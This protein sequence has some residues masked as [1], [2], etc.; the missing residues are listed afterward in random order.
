MIGHAQDVFGT[1]EE[2]VGL[3]NEHQLT[4]NGVQ[5]TCNVREIHEGISSNALQLEKETGALY[6]YTEC[7]LST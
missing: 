2:V 3:E 5:Q 6:Y 1:A 7:T 4:W